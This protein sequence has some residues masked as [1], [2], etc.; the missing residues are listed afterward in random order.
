L[1][2]SEKGSAA[3]EFALLAVPLILIPLNVISMSLF[4]YAQAVVQD[5]AVEGARYAALADQVSADGCE[6][7]LTLARQAFAGFLELGA[8][9]Q[10]LNPT[11]SPLEQVVVSARVPIFGLFSFSP[12]V[13]ATGRAP[14]EDN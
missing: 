7:A 5:S 13:S 1:F 8:D 9:C 14:R 2:K 11:G 3:V 4:S 6:R 12:Q 10:L